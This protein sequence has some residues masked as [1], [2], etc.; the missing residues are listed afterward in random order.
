MCICECIYTYIYECIC[1]WVYTYVQICVH[2]LPAEMKGR[3]NIFCHAHNL[4]CRL[5]PRNH[6]SISVYIY[7]HIHIR[8]CTH[9]HIY[10]YTRTHMCNTS[11][12]YSPQKRAKVGKK[13]T[14]AVSALVCIC[15]YMYTHTHTHTYIY[16]RTHICMT[17]RKEKQW[18][19]KFVTLTISNCE[20]DEPRI[21]VDG[22]DSVS[23]SL[24]VLHLSSDVDFHLVCLLRH[25][26]YYGVATVSRID[27]IIGLFCRI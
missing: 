6:Y 13:K 20:C 23:L 9:I 3:N 16:T 4:T 27:Q 24:T 17:C 12:M 5:F 21:R 15:I 10:I 18:K 14:F 8:I 22:R 7:I 2:L 1:R 26:M 19:N 25:R 11:R